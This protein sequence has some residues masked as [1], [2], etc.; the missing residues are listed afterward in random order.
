M[1]IRHTLVQDSN[2]RIVSSQEQRFLRDKETASL[3]QIRDDTVS[4]YELCFSMVEL[5]E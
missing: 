3:T 5:K 1:R 4:G 2:E